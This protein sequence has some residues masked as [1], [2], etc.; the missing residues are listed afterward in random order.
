MK[1]TMRKHLYITRHR[2]NKLII[3]ILI[4]FGIICVQILISSFAFPNTYIADINVCGK[5][6]KQIKTLLTQKSTEPIKIKIKDRIYRFSNQNLGISIDTDNITQKVFTPNRTW[7]PKNVVL[8]INSLFKRHDINNLLIFSDLFKT[9]FDDTVFDFSSGTD[10]ILLNQ[11]SKTLSYTKNEE[12][13]RVNTEHL[14]FL[15]EHNFYLSNI[16]EPALTQLPSRAQLTV[17]ASNEKIEQVWSKPLRLHL[18]GLKNKPDIILT[19]DDLKNILLITINENSGFPSIEINDSA[20]MNILNSRS[21][22]KSFP[23]GLTFSPIRTKSIMLEA[24]RMRLANNVIE[25]IN[26]PLDG[27]P[28]TDG[29]KAAKY[30][31]ADLTEQS[32]YLFH[33][34]YIDDS[35][36]ISSGLYFPTPTG[37]FKILNKLDK[38]YSDIYHV[39]MPWWMAFGYNQESNAYFGIHEL[40]YTVADDGKIKL[41]SRNLIGSPSTG[42]CIALDIGTAKKVY[43]WADIGTPVYIFK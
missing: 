10:E 33:N 25:S 35:F 36:R 15:L 38:A 16:I 14:Q 5:T 19:A 18:T 22:I 30:I 2:I 11:K 20:L 43:D 28:K 4:A 13:Y 31:E 37:E 29:T 41:P 23:I 32:M 40:P 3:S 27:G 17:E 7:F 1:L 8:Y 34:G 39:W 42:G 12:K 26:I 21:L 6:E 9:Y 24:I